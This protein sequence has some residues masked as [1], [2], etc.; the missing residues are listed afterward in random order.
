[1][2]G[3]ALGPAG[4]GGP[5]RA[6]SGGYV[7][8]G[9]SPFVVTTGGGGSASAEIAGVPGWIWVAGVIVAGAVAWKLYRKT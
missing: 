7:Q 9:D 3:K 8:F 5:S 1:M 4:G 6:D 2:L